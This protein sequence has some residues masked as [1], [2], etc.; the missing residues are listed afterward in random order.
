[1][2]KWRFFKEEDKYYKELFWDGLSYGEFNL[3][4]KYLHCNWR[5]RKNR[6][7]NK[8]INKGW[9]SYVVPIKVTKKEYRLSGESEQ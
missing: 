8:I 9:K 5:W 4:R 1:M 7:L 2:S 6:L 3:C